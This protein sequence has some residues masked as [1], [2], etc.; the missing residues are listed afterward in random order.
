MLPFG[1]GL[2][3]DDTL[4]GVQVGEELIPPVGPDDLQA[5]DA[6]G[7]AEAEVGAVVHAGHEAA[8]G[9]VVEILAL[10]AGSDDERGAEAAVIRRVSAKIDANPVMG[11][12]VG[13]LDIGVDE[14]R[15]VDVVHDEV[16]APIAIEIG[17]GRAVGEARTLQPP[18]A[19]LVGEADA[20]LVAEDVVR[21][22]VRGQVI[23]NLHASTTRR[24]RRAWDQGA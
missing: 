22:P 23:E 20:A 1:V 8:V 5:V 24:R 13:W 18:R 7:L 4:V 16:E 11:V 2:L 9:R 6:P 19:G 12:V 15:G 21:L 10:A 17:V 14:G 3:H